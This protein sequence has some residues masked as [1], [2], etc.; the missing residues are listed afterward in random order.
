MEEKQYLE[1]CDDFLMLANELES[2]KIFI[3]KNVYDYL[4]GIGYE[5]N[6]IVC[7]DLPDDHV[8][9]PELHHRGGVFHMDTM[10]EI[11]DPKYRI[12]T[13]NG[14]KSLIEIFHWREN[15]SEVIKPL[16]SIA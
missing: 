4:L 3:A 6:R 13:I 12:D 7:Y 15:K 8:Y 11:S 14:N 1:K 16:K 10:S 2:K 9:L 5:D